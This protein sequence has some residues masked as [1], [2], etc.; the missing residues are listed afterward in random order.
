VIA[1]NGSDE[2]FL[3]GSDP[4]APIGDFTLNDQFF[5]TVPPSLPGGANSGSIDLFDI[6]VGS[7]AYGIYTGSYFLLGGADG[8]ASENLAGADFTIEVVPE[9][10]TAGLLGLSAAFAFGF[11]RLRRRNW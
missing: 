10:G 9:P 3:N 4:T 1:N 7:P 6:Q 2:V 11:L 8:G 5:V